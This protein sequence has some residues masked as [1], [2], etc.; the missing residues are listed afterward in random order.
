MVCCRNVNE[1]LGCT[2]GDDW[3]WQELA[4]NKAGNEG[5]VIG[6]YVNYGP[7]AVA[8]SPTIWACSD[9]PICPPQQC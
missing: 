9:I 6:A 4:L 2:R 7:E 3:L 8:Q 5:K 1:Q